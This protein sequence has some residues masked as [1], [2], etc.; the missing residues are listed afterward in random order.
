MNPWRLWLDG[1]IKNRFKSDLDFWM[2]SSLEIDYIHFIFTVYIR[3]Y[4]KE[5]AWKDRCGTVVRTKRQNANLIHRKCLLWFEKIK[6]WIL[7]TT[8]GVCFAFELLLEMKIFISI[9]RQTLLQVLKTLWN[10]QQ[11]FELPSYNSIQRPF[12]AQVD[13]FLSQICKSDKK[14]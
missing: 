10:V 14:R 3:K 5:N 1:R 2:I 8:D 12:E 11:V 4:S 9:G 7:E 13:T 6:F